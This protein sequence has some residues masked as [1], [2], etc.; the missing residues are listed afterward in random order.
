[1]PAMA[2]RRTLLVLLLCVLAVP[3]AQARTVY[4]CVRDGTV[5]LSTAPEP[6]SKCVAKHI[7]DDAA[8]VPNLWGELGTVRGTLYERQQDGKTVYVENGRPT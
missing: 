6:G 7:D 4:R 8:K 5:S 3:A 1:M 2:T